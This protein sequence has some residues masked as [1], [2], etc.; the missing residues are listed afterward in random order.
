MTCGYDWKK[1]QIDLGKLGIRQ[2]L[3]FSSKTIFIIEESRTV[4][5]KRYRIKCLSTLD[6]TGFFMTIELP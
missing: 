1:T 4:H 5:Q 6:N 2:N 3:D